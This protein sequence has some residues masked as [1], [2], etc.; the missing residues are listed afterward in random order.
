MIDS[1]QLPITKTVTIGKSE[2]VFPLSDE[3]L[4]T[5][6]ANFQKP[7]LSDGELKPHYKE[8]SFADESVGAIT[9]TYSTEKQGLEIRR[10]DVIVKPDPVKQQTVNSIYIE[11]EFTRNDTSF[12]QR[13]FWKA[14]KNFQIITGR[15]AGGKTLPVEQLKVIWDPS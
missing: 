3:E 5:L 15:S 14:G 10:M 9:F 4:K 1:F 2:Q 11:K 8:N 13:L 7:N 12:T 6:A